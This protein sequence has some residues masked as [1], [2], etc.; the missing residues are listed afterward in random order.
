MSGR[1][2]ISALYFRTLNFVDE[3]W[4]MSI[5]GSDRLLLGG[6]PI[7]QRAPARTQPQL[8]FVA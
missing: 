1:M 3:R 7:F 5:L 2:S 4:F 8:F 6:V